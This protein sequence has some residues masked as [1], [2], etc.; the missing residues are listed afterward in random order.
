VNRKFDIL[1]VGAGSAGSVLASRLSEDETCQV[2][3]I[4]AGQMP[5]DPDISDPLKWPA[6][7]G[8]AYDW[9]Y[10]TVPQ[11]FTADRV[12]DWPRG[13]IV[14]GSSCLHAMAHVRGHPDDFDT[15]AQAGGD[16]WSY[17]GLLPGFK[18]SESFAA[19]QAPG[20][21]ADGP[22]DVY[23]PDEEVAPVVRP[24]LLPARRS[25]YRN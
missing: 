25:A 22:L 9:A 5:A 7:P 14:G 8:R 18:R 15:W 6:L 20:R 24:S 3:L 11:P 21:G 23:L 16:R 19:F 4:E 13:R 17:A 10:R 1:I 12:H 2:G